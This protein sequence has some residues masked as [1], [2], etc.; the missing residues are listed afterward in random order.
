[1][2]K[3]IFIMGIYSFRNRRWEFTFWTTEFRHSRIAFDM[4][5]Y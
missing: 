2:E 1:M 4:L 5:S 3:Y